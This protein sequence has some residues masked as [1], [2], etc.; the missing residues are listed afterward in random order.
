MNIRFILLLF[1]F[2]CNQVDNQNSV[3]KTT[4]KNN[5]EVVK[6]M[7]DTIFLGLYYGMSEEKYNAI[8]N[9]KHKEGIIFKESNSKVYKYTFKKPIRNETI[10]SS[11]KKGNYTSKKVY[12]LEYEEFTFDIE[13]K[14]DK[15]LGL[16]RLSLSY[17][18]FKMDGHLKTK[19]LDLPDEFYD[20]FYFIS[21]TYKNK[22][23]DIDCNEKKSEPNNDIKTS[24]K[25]CK[26]NK[27]NYFIFVDLQKV[28]AWYSNDEF[29]NHMTSG[30]SLI[31]YDK[32]RTEKVNTRNKKIL[33]NEENINKS[34][35][36]E[37]IKKVEN[38]TLDNI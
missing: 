31:Y 7:S 28:Y 33:E 27:N 11:S 15:E 25:T 13:P 18:L 1:I 5:Q 10:V 16:Y 36:E 37:K 8:L 24:N 35:V 9:K 34:Q 12:E 38:E 29:L 22:Y 30:L 17:D 23:G 14:I 4:V 32:N 19:H 2:S 6:N 20:F 21:N 26:W 3:D